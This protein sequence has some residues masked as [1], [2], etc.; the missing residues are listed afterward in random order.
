MIELD[1]RY[2][3]VIVNRYKEFYQS[4][5]E[6]YLMRNGEKIPYNEVVTM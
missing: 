2:T 5:E 3:D 1:E 4:D 6:I